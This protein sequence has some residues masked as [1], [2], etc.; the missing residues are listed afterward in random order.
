MQNEA[1][2]S[3]E[4]KLNMLNNSGGKLSRILKQYSSFWYILTP[5]ISAHM[6]PF[7][8]INTGPR[9]IGTRLHTNIYDPIAIY[10]LTRFE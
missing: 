8:S 9:A 1:G 6:Q 2:V 4:S 10:W 3:N 7:S 5:Y